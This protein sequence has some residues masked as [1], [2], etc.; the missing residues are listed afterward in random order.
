MS[1][2]EAL[3]K[4]PNSRPVIPFTRARVTRAHE[5]GEAPVRS[6]ASAR[7]GRLDAAAASDERLGRPYSR[8]QTLRHAR[9]N[10]RVLPSDFFTK[11]VTHDPAA[12]LDA[13]FA[14]GIPPRALAAAYRVTL[15]LERD[16][17]ARVMRRRTKQTSPPIF[18][19]SLTS[20]CKRVRRLAVT[21]PARYGAFRC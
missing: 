17:V 1:F 9:G 13:G 11:G 8:P 10:A 4:L 5:P 3:L 20:T 16:K 19:P 6:E 12:G 21:A 7:L 2:A 15:H 14:S 18:E